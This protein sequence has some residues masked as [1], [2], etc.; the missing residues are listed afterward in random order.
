[1]NMKRRSFLLGAAA[2]ASFPFIASAKNKKSVIWDMPN[3]YSQ[4]TIHGKGDVVLGEKIAEKTDGK[5]RIRHFFGGALG[6]KGSEMLDV[7]GSGA[8][9]IGGTMAAPLGGIDPIF[10]LSSLPFL[11]TSVSQAKILVE[12]ARKEYEDVCEKHNQ[13]L[14]IAAPWTPSGLWGK[15]PLDSVSS[16][17]GLRVRV[18]DSYAIRTFKN[19]GAAPK[20]VTMGEV[21]SQVSAGALDAVLTGS[22]AGLQYSIWEFLPC[23]T[24]INY[25]IPLNIT[26]INIDVWN[27]LTPDLQDAVQSA[28]EE[29]TEW[30]WQEL[31]DRINKFSIAM[32][33]HGGTVVN[34]LD[35]VYESSLA[36]A[37]EPAINDWLGNMGEKGERLLNKYRSSI[38]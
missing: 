18:Y 26:T 7:I 5:I 25:S 28:A 30:W 38:S 37:A 17:R 32:K 1:M 2:L 33:D 14:L 9:Q 8:A 24:A 10:Y 36:K 11:A 31:E 3:E 22:Y 19:L 27:N 13:R 16:L 21:E 23:F 34:D 15:H 35:S 29:T 6:Y 12:V 20:L 4:G